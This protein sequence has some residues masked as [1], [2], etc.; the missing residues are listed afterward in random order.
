MAIV[1]TKETKDGA[2]VEIFEDYVSLFKKLHADNIFIEKMTDGKLETINS[3]D[4]KLNFTY[5]VIETKGT[6]KQLESEMVTYR[7]ELREHM[8]KM[9][10]IIDVP[11]EQMDK[12]AKSFSVIKEK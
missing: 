5:G 8:S 3:E 10:G 9:D 12:L 1:L 7:N 6:S 2:V 11:K 4:V